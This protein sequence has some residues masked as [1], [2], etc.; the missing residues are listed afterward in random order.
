MSE[1][2]D[3]LTNEASNGGISSAEIPFSN[4]AVETGN[5][6]KSPPEKLSLRDQINK[7]VEA[8][9]KEEATRVRDTATGKFAK[10]E[11]SA[12]E[13]PAAAEIPKTEQNAQPT[14]SKPVGPPSGWS[15]EAQAL[16]DQLPP[17]VKADAVRREAEVA[18]GFDEYRGKTAQLVEISQAFEPLKPILQQNGIQTEAQAVKRLLE[19]EGNFRNPETRI[20]SFQNLARQYGID[21]HSLVQNSSPQPS[22]AQEI[23]EPLRPV[24]DQFGNIVQDVNSIKAELQ[25]SRDEN[26][27]REL[28]AFAKDK[29][30]FDKVRVMMGQLMQA[31]LA[32]DLEGAYQKATTLHPEVSAT[33]EAEKAAKAAAELAKT[34]SEKVARARAASI[35]PSQRAPI[36]A[37]NGGAKPKASSVR[38]SLLS[39]I[40]ELREGQRA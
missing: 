4:G 8:V 29:P 19:W 20:Q 18:K 27:S 10:V 26:I 25:R 12:V 1:L 40:G 17:A 37:V 13:K 23:P 22:S 30:H 16:W 28:S 36:G 6:D 38:A 33:I 24:I 2:A 21:I 7:S 32:N 15:K 34:N 3:E 35:S 5:Q 11:A 31:G 39:S 9:R 14:E